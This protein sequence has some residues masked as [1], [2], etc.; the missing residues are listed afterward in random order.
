MTRLRLPSLL[1]L[2]FL[3]FAPAASSQN[4][5]ALEAKVD[6][7]V[8]P[9]L[10]SHNFSGSVLIARGDKVLV[11]KGYGMANYELD[12]ANTPHTK[13]QIAS[14][15]KPFT[16]AAI[17]LLEERGKLKLKHPLAKFIRDYPQGD[18]ITI[19]QLLAHSSGIVNANNLPGYREKSRFHQSL[20]QVIAMFKGTPLLFQPGEKFDY[21]NSNYN[22]LAYVIEKASGETYGD[23]LR[24]NIFEPLGMSDTGEPH[25]DEIIRNHASGYVPRGMSDVQNAPYLDWSI[26]TGNGSLYSSVEDLYKFDRALYTDKLLRRSSRDQMFK[27]HF[28]GVGYAWFIGKKLNRRAITYTGRSPGYTTALLRFVED[29]ATVILA[30]NIYSSL[31]RSMADDLAA[32]LFGEPYRVPELTAHPLDEAVLSALPGRYQFGPDFFTP[33]L[34]IKVEARQHDLAIATPDEIYL[35]P[36]SDGSFIDRGYGGKMSFSRDEQGKVNQLTWS[37]GDAFVAKRLPD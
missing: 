26:K 35:I 7:Y 22:L 34:V 36:Q 32:I 18:K 23:F 8:K 2:A 13:F 31:T 17:L 24:K 28:E 19:H 33:N 4:D 30:S 27:E 21:S 1:L 37:F 16:A 14:V 12:V 20:D 3:L 10:E 11:S 25:A 29:D 5:P 6:A 9:Y 15:S